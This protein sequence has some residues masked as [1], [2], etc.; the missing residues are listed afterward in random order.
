LVIEDWRAEMKGFV[1]LRLKIYKTYRRLG[2]FLSRIGL[3]R[4]PGAGRLYN[5]LNNK[6]IRPKGIFLLNIQGNKIYVKAMDGGTAAVLLG[7]SAYEKYETELFEKMVQDGMVVVDIG[8]NIGYYTLIAAKLVGKKGRI[9]AFEPEASSYELLCK[10]IQANG[11]TNIVP[12]EKAVSKTTG[13]TKLYVDRALTDI[14]SFGKDNVLPYSKNA[15]CLEV[16][17]ITLDD[18][19][20][21]AVGDDRIDFMKI[22]VEGAEELVVDGADRI[23]RNNRLK[24]LI[25]FVP[26]QLRNVGAEPPE[27]LYKLQNYGFAIKLLNDRKQVLEPIENIEEFC[28]SVESRRNAKPGEGVFNLLLEK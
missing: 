18:F 14:S 2:G 12:I 20:E 11:Y 4:I 26:R 19:F 1:S 8:A 27:L 7:G 24:I 17:T 21:R 3:G 25:E 28:R 13:K 23:L 9:Y 5:L 16:E 10:N 6:F 22:D 15:D